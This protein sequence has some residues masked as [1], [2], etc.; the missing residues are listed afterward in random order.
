MTGF[1][2]LLFLLTARAG[3]ACVKLPSIPNLHSAG[4]CADFVVASLRTDVCRRRNRRP[5]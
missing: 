5:K 1:P 2:L 3:L 4:C